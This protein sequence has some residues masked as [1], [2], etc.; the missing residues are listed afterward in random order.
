MDFSKYDLTLQKKT[1]SH[2][3][4]NQDQN[5]SSGLFVRSVKNS[6]VQ[7]NIILKDI[8]NK[9]KKTPTVRL[10]Y[11]FF[12]KDNNCM[13]IRMLSYRH[14]HSFIPVTMLKRMQWINV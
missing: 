10:K 14:Y 11:I 8:I 12:L 9:F 4:A 13:L 5:A 2:F 6:F 1:P 7:S 3:K